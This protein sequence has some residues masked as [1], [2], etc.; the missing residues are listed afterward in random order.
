MC[1]SLCVIG[2]GRMLF[3]KNSDRPTHE[4]QVARVFPRRPAANTTLQTNLQTNLQTT[5][6]TNLRTQYLDLGADPGA[7]AFVGSQPS[8]LWGV[9]HGVNE[10]GVAIG[11]EKIWTTQNPKG[12]PEALLGMDLVRLGLERATTASDARSIITELVERH[13]QGG[14]G[15]AD[16]HE[17]YF[18]SFLIAD[19]VEAWV[20]ETNGHDWA[21]RRATGRG[22]ALS[23]RVSLGTDWEM[24]SVADSNDSGGRFDVQAWRAPKVP[25]GIAD[26]RLGA[27]TECV[28]HAATPG[29]IVAALR[30]HGTHPWGDPMST[31]FVDPAPIPAEPGADFRGVTVCMHVR[32]YQC[33]TASM[34]AELVA[35]PPPERACTRLWIALGSPCVSVYVPVVHS[36]VAEVLQQANTWHRF[37]RLRISAEESHDAAIEIRSVWAPIE[38]ALWAQADTLDGNDDDVEDRAEFT[39][40]IEMQLEIGFRHL[41]V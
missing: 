26:H 24:S 12:H 16:H 10:F 7:F 39:A 37:E 17:P 23:N 19:P 11:N 20:V 15:E 31:Q 2:D 38:S 33:T 21:A 18:S 6:Q 27:T 9:E 8:W 22:H 30:H 34:V 36:S 28:Q 13:G 32:D 25:T 4:V 3:A 40:E 5:A 1:D 29:A 41:S 14:T 35:S